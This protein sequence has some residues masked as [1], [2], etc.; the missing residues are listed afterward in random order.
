MSK[1]HI[2]K[3]KKTLEFAKWTVIS[4][5]NENEYADFW[6]ISR[7]NGDI[8]LKLKFMIMGNGDFGAHT[9]NETICNAINC[10]VDNY[11]DISLYFGKYS[12]KFQEDLIYFINQLNAIEKNST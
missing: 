7:P 12:R 5:Y 8:P 10:Q 2:E 1:A 11:P 9:G 3:L 6:M 4:D